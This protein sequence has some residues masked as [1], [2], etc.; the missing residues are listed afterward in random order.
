MA[1]KIE[2]IIGVIDDGVIVDGKSISCILKAKRRFDLG[3]I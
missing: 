1:G 2:I 3:D